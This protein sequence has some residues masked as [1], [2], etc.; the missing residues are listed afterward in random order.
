MASPK[1]YSKSLQE[2]K[3]GVID[4]K[5]KLIEVEVKFK[6]FEKI[7]EIRKQSTFAF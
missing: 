6:K 5:K 2:I 3:Q 1:E 4:A 7:L